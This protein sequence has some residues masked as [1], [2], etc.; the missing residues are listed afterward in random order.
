MTTT[1]LIPATSTVNSVSYIRYVLLK[2]IVSAYR[3]L[4]VAALTF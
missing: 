3:L 2:L 4:S 1:V